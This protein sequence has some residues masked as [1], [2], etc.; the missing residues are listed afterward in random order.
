VRTIPRD[1]RSGNRLR[2][3]AEL[4]E[5][6]EHGRERRAGFKSIPKTTRVIVCATVS[7]MLVCFARI[8]ADLA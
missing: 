3:I 7:G 4:V 1:G 6:V 8:S 2:Q 5:G